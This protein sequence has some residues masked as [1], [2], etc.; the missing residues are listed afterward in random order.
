[1]AREKITT[2]CYIWVNGDINREKSGSNNRCVGFGSAVSTWVA[3]GE[4]EHL[5]GALEKPEEYLKGQRENTRR[6][7]GG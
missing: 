1:V 7:P 5:R 2:A 4:N 6:K 3:K